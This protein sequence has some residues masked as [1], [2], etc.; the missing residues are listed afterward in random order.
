MSG[1]YT[2]LVFASQRKSSREPINA[3]LNIK[4]VREKKKK[5]K[6]QVCVITLTTQ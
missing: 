1:S 4:C 6:K 2:D 3:A 5:K